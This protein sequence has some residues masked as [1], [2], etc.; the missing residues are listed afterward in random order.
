MRMIGGTKTLALLAL[1]A[2]ATACSDTPTRSGI[3]TGP[4]NLPS[5]IKQQALGAPGTTQFYMNGEAGRVTVTNER[6]EAHAFAFVVFN[7]DNAGNQLDYGNDVFTLEHGETAT[8]TVGVHRMPGDD[9]CKPMRLQPDVFIDP[10]ALGPNGKF[11]LGELS[12]NL[13]G[14]GAYGTLP[15]ESTGCTVAPP[16]PPPPPPPSLCGPGGETRVFAADAWLMSYPPDLSKPWYPNKL[17]PF[18]MTAGLWPHTTYH[19]TGLSGDPGHITEPDL[20]EY[21]KHEQWLVETDD[22]QRT[23]PSQDVPE[24]APTTPVDLGYLTIG[25]NP[26]MSY[27]IIHAGPVF[28]R[29]ADSVRPM[30]LVFTEVCPR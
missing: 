24:D 13:Y 17:G 22:G 25:D 28:D 15:A 2:M 18:P 29:A 12:N 9:P 7:A 23:Q 8:R 14:G 5:A 6:A 27:T 26:V 30:I 20:S 21:Q 19:V 16:P 1:A 11:T 10:P 3:A 4:T